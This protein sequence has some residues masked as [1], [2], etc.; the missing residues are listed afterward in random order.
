M[1]FV[2][3]VLANPLNGSE[4]FQHFLDPRN[5][6]PGIPID[7]ISY[8]FYSMPDADETPETMQYTIFNQADNF[9]TAVR[10]I[11]S[12]RKRF[13]PH[14]R[15]YIDEL[16]SMLP[17]PTAPRLAHPIPDSYWNLSGG[18]WAYIYGHL[19]LNRDRLRRRHR[20]H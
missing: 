10:Y 12:I 18:M 19:A 15:T 6:K 16:G 14:T 2:G 4:Y 13:S 5:H 11:E 1:E 8:H 9:L 7:M 20:A 17:D 3:L